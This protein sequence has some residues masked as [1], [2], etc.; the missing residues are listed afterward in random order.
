MVLIM[1]TP[2]LLAQDL[3][4]NFCEVLVCLPLTIRKALTT[5]TCHVGEV[6]Q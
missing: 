4:K 2:F 5:F 1:S 3:G 6:A